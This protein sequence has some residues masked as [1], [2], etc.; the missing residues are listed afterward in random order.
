MLLTVS[1]SKKRSLISTSHTQKFSAN[2]GKASTVI[3][4]LP[5][6]SNGA[7]SPLVL[8]MLPLLPHNLLMLSCP[9]EPR[10]HQTNDTHRH[11]PLGKSELEQEAWVRY[12]PDNH[13]T[14]SYPIWICQCTKDHTRTG[15]VFYRGK[16]KAAKY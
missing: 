5:T 9:K 3:S 7:G 2:K 12:K 6:F 8:I 16:N 1:N 15:H 4:M 13:F 10:K 14:N 11:K